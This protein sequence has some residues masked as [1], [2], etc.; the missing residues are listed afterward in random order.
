MTELAQHTFPIIALVIIL[1]A[2][3]A[4]DVYRGS[5]NKPPAL[6]IFA[7]LVFLAFC[8]AATLTLMNITAAIAF[9]LAG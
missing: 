6:R 3:I 2:S 9:W 1:G 7:A 8:M 5:D 4:R